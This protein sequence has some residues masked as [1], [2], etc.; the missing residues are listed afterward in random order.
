M[1]NRKAPNQKTQNVRGPIRLRR[2]TPSEFIPD[3]MSTIY[4]EDTTRGRTPEHVQMLQSNRKSRPTFL[5]PL[6]T[7]LASFG[8]IETRCFRGCWLCQGDKILPMSSGFQRLLYSEPSSKLQI[9]TAM[10]SSHGDLHA[11]KFVLQLVKLAPTHHGP[12]T[13][14]SKPSLDPAKPAQDSKPLSSPSTIGLAHA[15]MA[16]PMR[17]CYFT[18]LVHSKSRG[19]W[20]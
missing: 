4:L 14:A 5:V 13:S 11:S 6:T 12:S 10:L 8:R 7:A 16:L 19:W 1:T 18:A 17:C 20:C 15:M 2:T 9:A 3:S